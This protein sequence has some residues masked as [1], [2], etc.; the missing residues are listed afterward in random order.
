M[1]ALEAD[2]DPQDVLVLN[3]GRAVQICVDLA[4][5][6][7]SGLPLP[8][9]GV[10]FERLAEAGILDPELSLRMRKA[11]GFRNIA[12]HAY[13]TIDWRSSTPSPRTGCGASR[14]SPALPR[15]S[16]L[17]QTNKGSFGGVKEVA[18][19]YPAPIRGT[20]PGQSVDGDA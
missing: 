16:T 17:A 15:N 18:A 7:L 3:L 12:V 14:H 10:A 11:V 6:L 20:P 8:P 2:I 13:D 19:Q 4:T 5:N 1:E 9:M